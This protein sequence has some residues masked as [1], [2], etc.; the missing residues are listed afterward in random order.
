MTD[1]TWAHRVDFHERA[2][3]FIPESRLAVAITRTGG[4][5][6]FRQAQFAPFELQR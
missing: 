4:G 3:A 5:D 6:R 1:S 2:S